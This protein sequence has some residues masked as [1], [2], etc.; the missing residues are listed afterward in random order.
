MNLMNIFLYAQQAGAQSTQGSMWSTL[1]MI[2][3]L[4]LIFWLFF[5]RPQSKKN[6]EMQKFRDSLKKGDRIVTI[7]GIHGKIVDFDGNTV[8]IE[9]EGQ[10]KIRVEKSAIQQYEAGSK[11]S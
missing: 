8:I 7:G 6:K 1:I 10:G 4:I 5:I 2:L 3:L 11:E 9:T